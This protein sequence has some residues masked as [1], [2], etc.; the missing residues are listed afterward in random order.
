M[1]SAATFDRVYPPPVVVRGDSM[2]IGAGVPGGEA[3]LAPWPERPGER[4]ERP[5]PKTDTLDTYTVM[6]PRSAAPPTTTRVPPTLTA[7]ARRASRSA[8]ETCAAACTTAVP[9]WS[10]RST[11]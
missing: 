4:G 9:P 3:A 5:A 6:S 1:R 10:A 7:T 11:L 2:V 8:S